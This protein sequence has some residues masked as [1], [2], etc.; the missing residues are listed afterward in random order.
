MP[1]KQLGRNIETRMKKQLA[2]WMA[3]VMALTAV[4][5]VVAA[6]ESSIS[7]NSIKYITA[8]EELPE[9]IAYIPCEEK[10]PIEEVMEIMPEELQVLYEGDTEYS[11]LAV[12]WVCDEDYENT[13]Y[14]QYEFYPQWEESEGI[15]AD[16]VEVPTILIEINIES[17]GP[18]RDLE[19]AKK[20]LQKISQKKEI[21]ALVYLTD[22]YE[23]RESASAEAGTIA[24]VE[25]GQTVEIQ[26]VEVDENYNI[27]YHVAF[28]LGENSYNGYVEENYLAVSDEA[29]LS[30]QSKYKAPGIALM[31]LES[32]Y[33][34]VEQFPASYQNALYELK[35]K[36]PG[37]TFVKMN[38]G[39]D[40]NTVIANERKGEKNCV[41][42]I[43]P[44]SWKDTEAKTAGSGWYTAT[45]GV[46]KYYMDPRNFLT[47]PYIFQFE[48]L[49]Y[50][51]SYHTESA[52]QTILNSSFMSGEIPG[53]GM[54]YAHAFASLGS[55]TKV[56]PFHLAARV[57]Q[58]QGT[59][60]TSALISGT[61]S[62]YE[63]YYNYFNVGAS[64]ANN[65]AVIINGLKKAK[66]NGWNT[67]YK[68]LS[69]GAK[70]LGSNYIL[71]GQDTLYLE[72][73]NVS[74]Y[75]TYEHQYMQNLQ[76]PYSES[77]NIRK[78]YANAGA[79]ENTFVF[80]IP[81]YNDMPSSACAKP[82]TTD[83][84]TLSKTTVDNLA[85]GKTETV[86]AYMNG[87]MLDNTSELS[88][89][90]SDNSVATVDGNGKITAVSPGTATITCAR[91]GASSA[92]CKVTVI[93]ADPS[94]S[95]PTVAPV[96]YAEGLT[97]A[98]VTLPSG[99]KWKNETTAIKTGTASYEAVYTPS[100]TVKYNTVTKQ[101]SVTVTKAIPTYVALEPVELAV[102]DTLQK[103]TLPSGYAWE[104]DGN[105]LLS[106]A[107]KYVF[108]VSYNP[109]EA[110]YHTITGIPLTV[111]VPEPEKPTTSDE[112]TSKGSTSSSST[113]TPS[114]G[115]STGST[116][117]P[118][119]GTSTGST[120]TPST[121]TSTGSTSTP[122]TGTS[123]GS[124]ST[125]STGTSAGSTST[126]S[127]GS[128][129]SPSTGS[130]ST[131]S[132][133]TSAGSTSSPSTGTSTG[134][135]STPSTGTSTGS[136]STPS[137]GTSTGSTS[138]PSTGTSTGSTS[139][140]GT[141]TSTGS[142]SSSSTSTPSTG[143]STGST[144]TPSTGTSTG[145]TSS[146]ST[147]TSTES[148]STPSTTTSVA[149]TS[150]PSTNTSSA[151][152]SGGN[153][154]A[155]STTTTPET[156]N[157]VNTTPAQENTQ[158]TTDTPTT[159]N[160]QT[161]TNTQ[162]A[163]TAP[164]VEP[165]PTAQATDRN[166]A[167]TSEAA[168]NHNSL[169]TQSEAVEPQQEAQPV[170]E[171]AGEEQ[172]VIQKPV[173][174]VAMNDTTILTTD[175]IKMAKEQNIDLVLSMDNQIS[176]V[177]DTDS[178]DLE[179]LENIDM[180]V[181]VN[182]GQIPQE[183]YSQLTEGKACIEISLAHDGPF[184]FTPQLNIAIG[185]MESG[186]YANL[187][188]YN[189]ESG[190]LEFMTASLID[191]DGNAA[192]TFEHASDYMIIV[193]DAPMAAAAVT[194]EKT[195][196]VGR[197]LLIITIL[198]IILAGAGC[199]I[200]LWKRR[201]TEEEETQQESEEEDED[202]TEDE[203]GE[204]EAVNYTLENSED[205]YD[206]TDYEEDTREE[207][208]DDSPAGKRTVKASV[209]KEE[210]P[211]EEKLSQEESEED[212]WIED[213]E[214]NQ[215]QQDTVPQKSQTAEQEESE[216]D[217]WIEDEEWEASRGKK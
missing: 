215:S 113:S 16:N 208:K 135:T 161:T 89:T 54:T 56:S 93:K 9:E 2:L 1:C 24:T 149:S 188:Y 111:V 86:E 148:A 34:D 132:T 103:V 67:R 150:T 69:G 94:V 205:D 186:K 74:R 15:V 52:V 28:Y 204:L 145:S 68:S 61:Y 92:T 42:R 180:A 139:T 190:Q 50:N 216:E 19:Q 116:I 40:W 123:I 194:Q 106:K 3:G 5:P 77:Q 165:Q 211:G 138:T 217:D 49:T 177:I 47:D 175:Q 29:F 44:A 143:T 214:W 7:E 121:G 66:E 176:W 196:S 107:G 88:Y 99:W 73:F 151:N 142:T 200:F 170:E 82:D 27:W 84:I 104:S 198:L 122:S 72:K 57:L 154:N 59:K 6:E 35:R 39:L 172:S 114:T 83:K 14:S 197:W 173:V 189:P 163:T 192:F 79:L 164:T 117:T 191:E 21:L 136:T 101:I 33:A 147:G 166:T 70:I 8:F 12:D 137:T 206:E 45:E 76:A 199:G 51:A 183:V 174:V 102:G 157:T 98:A 48:Q 25:S 80:K 4:E 37:W 41:Y 115:T 187:F 32:G 153:N 125:P 26:N 53:E 87:S 23:V 213:E 184:S 124:T 110:N 156:G 71:R 162:A 169:L 146:P 182:A 63:G 159:T 13:E 36:H 126:P 91:S 207:K 155:P 100:D 167:G 46:I 181:T 141:G 160:A 96:T 129:S 131:P 152:S 112:S 10:A 119:T 22:T 78:A 20:E 55:S 134:S 140:P 108:Y 133:G 210:L 90:S 17:D 195:G 75:S 58:E 105:T 60:G 81:V 11:N 179:Q 43:S 62:G 118:S 128:T 31:G 202:E 144:S 64:G 109:D 97:L 38:T 65:Q 209:Q 203:Q 120:S 95:A 201:K 171:D 193:D 212:D 130:T 30:W 85:V 185:T 168:S 178:I 158:T 18:I 127:T